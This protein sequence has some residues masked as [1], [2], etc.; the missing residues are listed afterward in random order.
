[1]KKHAILAKRQH[2]RVG[3]GLAAEGRG[4]L[5]ASLLTIK[6]AKPTTSCWVGGKATGQREIQVDE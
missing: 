3:D 6:L 1:M 4:M 2:R 5:S